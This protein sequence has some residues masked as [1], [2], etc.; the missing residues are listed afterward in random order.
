MPPSPRDTPPLAL[1]MG[2]PRSGTTWLQRM[3]AAHPGVVSPQETGL[4]DLYLGR[5]YDR[6]ARQQGNMQRALGGLERGEVVRKRVLG[7]PSILEPEDFDELARSLVAKVVERARAA[8]PGAEVVLEKTPSNA[9]RV[10]LVDRLVPEARFV[11]IIRDPRDVVA[12][13]LGTRELMDW[14]WAPKDAG[15]AAEIWR[16]HVESALRGRALGPDRYLEIRYEHLKDDPNAMVARV[17]E[18]LGLDP[19]QLVTDERSLAQGEFV[20]A[21][22]VLRRLGGVPPEPEGFSGHGRVRH[23]LTPAQQ[24]AVEHVAGSLMTE[25]GY[26][27]GGRWEAPSPMHRLVHQPAVM[28]RAQ[29][30]RLARERLWGAESGRVLR[31]LP[32]P[33]AG[34]GWPARRGGRDE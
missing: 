32:V 28:A 7:L 12:S 1:V 27:E 6:W 29:A 18:F 4:F 10:D 23:S 9:L 34:E 25:L 22:T 3:L 14:Q 19:D 20:F 24:L 33:P 16:E 30:R 2:S 5:L 15:R 13:I 26:G 21:P 11:H 8:K 17:A 31:R